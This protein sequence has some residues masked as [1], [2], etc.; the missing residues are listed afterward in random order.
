MLKAEKGIAKKRILA[1]D[2]AVIILRKISDALER[3]A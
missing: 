1:V 2:D 3:Y